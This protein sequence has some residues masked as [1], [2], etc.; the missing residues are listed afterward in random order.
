MAYDPV[1]FI[2]STGEDLKEHREQAARA[3]RASSFSPRMMEYFPARGA[4]PSLSD[5]RDMVAQAEVVVV[6]VAHRYGWVPDDPSNSDAKSI[7]WLECEHAWNVTKKEVLAF[8][9]DPECEWPLD[10]YENYR[11]IKERKSRVS[12]KK[13]NATKRSWRSSSIHLSQRFRATF[14][15]ASSV[16]TLVGEA[17]AD[18]GKRHSSITAV[19]P[20]DPEPY[21]KYLEDDTRQIR[22]KGLKSKRAEPYFFG[23]DEVYIPLTTLAIR[24]LPHKDVATSPAERREVLE[25]A[26]SRQ[27]VVIGEPGSGKSTFLR[28]VAFELC[29]T[30]RETRPSDAPPFLAPDDRRF[31]HPHP[32]RRPCHAPRNR[33]L[34]HGARCTGLD[35]AL[36]RQTE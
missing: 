32:N 3:A 18:W 13:S 17:L 16:R 23:I 34:G 1:V 10:Q 11:L 22:V 5:C 26:L 7:T 28:R 15:D 19:A 29:R 4:Q 20:G 2:S 33:P 6:L 9:V 21:L 8:L 14:T 24:E 35:S 27:T 12:T 36:S 30:L 25:H 31:P